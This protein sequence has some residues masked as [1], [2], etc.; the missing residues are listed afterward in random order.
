MGTASVSLHQ[1]AWA[2]FQ[3]DLQLSRRM[4]S[5][6]MLPLVFLF[7]VIAMVPLGIG[8][9]PELLRAISPGMIWVAALLSGLLALD[10]LFKS[11]FEDGT[12]EQWWVGEQPVVTLASVRIF[13]HWLITAGPTILATP[14]AAQMLYLPND[15]LGLM[16][17]SLLLGTPI[18]SLVGA[19][20]A[21]L[22]LNAKGGSALVG[23]L[24]FPLIVPVLI[25]GT[26]AVSAALDGLT[27][28][29]F[30]LLLSALLILGITLVPI[31][32]V[33]ALKL[34]IE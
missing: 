28:R 22:T 24:V 16:L 11:D 7:S 1:P 18:M 32:T 3:R 31:A 15:V 5:Q 8:P 30:I 20:G 12:L 9:G 14:I 13:S 6:A 17:L 26:G 2:L 29:P 4:G 21:A 34:S 10:G 27:A 19:L 23:I 25:F 33:A